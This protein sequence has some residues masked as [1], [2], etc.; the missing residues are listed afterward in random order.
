MNYYLTKEIER[1]NMSGYIS[2]FP[3]RQPPVYSGRVYPTN[4]FIEFLKE[5]IE[6]SIPNRFEQQVNRYPNRIAIKTKTQEF[7]YEQLNKTANRLARALL[8]PRGKGEKTIALLLEKGAILIAAMLSVLKIGKIY[9]VL[10]PSFP[11]ARNAYILADSQAKL[12]V[13]NN[14]NIAL[15]RELAQENCQLLNVDEIDS[16]FSTDNMELSISPDTLAHIIYTSG[17]TGQPKGVVQNH[18]NVLHNCM[19]NTNAYHI[20]SD[21]RMTLLH[22]CSVLG[23]TRGIF[24]AKRCH[25]LSPRCQI[26]RIDRF[27]QLTH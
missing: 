14:G 16:V 8:S 18:R 6:Q 20:N 26:G 3:S 13:T 27:A 5:D 15:A 4:A 19:I 9:V 2:D 11:S 25:P 7:T 23:G 24:N 10:D 21:D 22:S 1:S 12:I 17:S